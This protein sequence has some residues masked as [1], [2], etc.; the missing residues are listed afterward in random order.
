MHSDINIANTLKYQFSIQA[1]DN[2]SNNVIGLASNDVRANL[3]RPVWNKMVDITNSVEFSLQE[4]D[5]IKE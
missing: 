4:I 2:V 5:T 1:W 3:F